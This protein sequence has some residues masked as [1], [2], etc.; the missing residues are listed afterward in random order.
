MKIFKK[1]A[2]VGLAAVLA[3][4]ASVP[5]FAASYAQPSATDPDQ[6]YMFGDIDR[7]GK[8]TTAD[9]RK[10]LRAACYLDEPPEETTLT[11]AS[12]DYDRDGILSSRDA[13]LVLRVS[14]KLDK[15]AAQQ[16]HPYASKTSISAQDAINR[17]KT[18]N[19]I[20]KPANTEDR[21]P[22][23]YADRQTCKVD[24]KMTNALKILLAGFSDTEKELKDMA[25]ETEAENTFNN[26]YKSVSKYGV[27][28][29]YLQVKN[30]TSVVF[31]DVTVNDIKSTAFSYNANNNTYTIRINF[32][33][34][35]VTITSGESPLRQAIGDIT[36]V[37]NLKAAAGVGDDSD[38][39]MQMTATIDKVKYDV[40]DSITGAY[41]QYTFNA[42]T[43]KPTAAEYGYNSTL[44]VPATIL[45]VGVTD[46]AFVMITKQNYVMN[47]IFEE[48]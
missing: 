25:K 34:S 40:R 8:V 3:A 23:Q 1:I 16:A 2:C 37:D 38:F 7:N 32:K 43:N 29:S 5:A 30:N 45:K 26:P 24:I 21:V 28:N 19:S 35:D 27:Y 20:L 22:F 11:Y 18:L 9:A 4:T 33:D 31:G 13:R 15:A 36:T 41:V 14:L 48:V 17:M 42:V 44:T 10:I 12:A 46:A 39:Q 6:W 47:Y